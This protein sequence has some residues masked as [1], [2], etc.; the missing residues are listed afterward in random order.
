M[1]KQKN[2]LQKTIEKHEA[3]IEDMTK[4]KTDALVKARR[5]EF[6]IQNNQEEYNNVVDHYTLVRSKIK[7]RDQTQNKINRHGIIKNENQKIQNRNQK[8]ITQNPTIKKKQN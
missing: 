7:K 4:A 3:I 6:W 2:K 8:Q 5:G 1:K